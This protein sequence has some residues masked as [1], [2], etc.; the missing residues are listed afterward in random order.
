MSPQYKQID[1]D[2]ERTIIIGDIHGC[3]EELQRL[4]DEID[5]SGT[6]LLIAVGDMVDRGPYPW[7]AAKFFRDTPNAH[8][9]LGNHERRVAGV[10][11][12]RSQPAWSQLHTLDKVVEAEQ[13]GWADYF[14]SLPA[15]IETPHAIVTHARLDPDKV[16][17]EQEP[18]FTCAVGGSNIKIEADETGIPLWFHQWR[19]RYPQTKPVC[20]GH[21]KYGRVE[22][23]S[24]ALYALDTDAVKGHQ[25][26]A[27]TLPSGDI[28]SVDSPN[29]YAASRAVWQEQELARR[30][31]ALPTTPLRDVDKMLRGEAKEQSDAVLGAAFD[32]LL[33]EYAFLQRVKELRKGLLFK[34]GEI[35]QDP[36]QRG[37]YSDCSVSC[38]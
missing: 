11:R 13:P 3:Y 33:D 35:P 4:L 14:E 9:V 18:Y 2:F 32:G 12:G 1:D 31:E 6:D 21:I 29:Y 25:L 5:F 37:G 38:W 26:T 30:V 16:L 8:S 34:F 20:I 36:L 19:E 24:G 7:E 10:I 15:V 27:L 22:L 23:D 28:A 17:S